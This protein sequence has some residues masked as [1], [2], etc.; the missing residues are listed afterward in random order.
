MSNPDA[1]LT[2]NPSIIGMA[3]KAH[4]AILR[5]ILKGTSLDEP[6]W[7]TLQMALGAGES[8]GRPD[9][10]EGVAR[11][12]RFDPPVVEAAIAAL[13]DA[14]LMEKVP[15]DAGRLAV[16]DAGR[17]LVSTLRGKVSEQINDAY[18]S[19]DPEDLATA[20]RVLTAVTAKLSDVLDPV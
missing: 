19:I 8:I 5:K 6:Q 10:V 4:S 13:I 16:T 15:G 2:L 3:E 12:A 9:L 14:S 11:A 7:I 17:A 18:G 20:A 1:P